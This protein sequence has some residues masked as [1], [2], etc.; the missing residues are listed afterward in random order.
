MTHE[1]RTTQINLRRKHKTIEITIPMNKFYTSMLCCILL[2]G[3]CSDAKE[4]K[5]KVTPVSLGKPVVS[6]ISYYTAVVQV[7]IK[8]DLLQKKVFVILQLPTPISQTMP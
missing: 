8:G 4:E 1:N 6:E 2:S 7:D 5:I 3:A